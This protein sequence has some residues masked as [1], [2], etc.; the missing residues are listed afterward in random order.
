MS[1]VTRHVLKNGMVVLLKEVHSA[2]IISWWVLYRI[3]SRNERTGT[4]GVSHWVEHM[5][6]KGTD[7]FPPG[8]L[9]KAIDRVGGQWNAQTFLDYTAYFETLPASEIDLALRLE[10]DRMVNA[11][12]DPEEVASERTVIISER[13]GSE[14]S[15]MFWLG[16]EMQAAAFRVHGYHHEIIGDMT[17][18]HTMTRDDLYNH[19]KK[20]YLPNN[21]I[22]VAVGDFDSATMLARIQEL[23]ENIPAGEP[24]DLFVRPEPDQMGERRLTIERPGTTAFIQVGYRVPAAT[25]PDWFKLELVN[26]LL[27]GPDSMGGG[28]IDNKTSRLYKALVDTELA[29][30][31]DG[32]MTQT[33]DPFLYLI[34]IVVR[35]GK[36]PEEVEAALNAEID[37]LRNGDVTEA[38]LNRVKKQ[39]RALFAYSTERV[40]SQAFWLAF[41]ENVDSYEWFD[42]YVANLEAVTLDEVKEAAARYLRPQNRTVGYFIPTEGE[43]GEESEAYME[44]A[45]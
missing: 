14:N 16:E 2:P 6:F 17:D 32:G 21:A 4:T 24:I 45:E 35:D 34:N 38:E 36:S 37:R 25:D 27:C 44:E 28:S 29:A 10:A 26:S 5:M 1:N 7:Q 12:F 18:L 39:A 31:V 40:T 3:G 13:Q 42:N 9:D 20:H 22:A 15:P 19:Y 43:M 30:S 8:Y 23:Y 33:I 41:T 11:K